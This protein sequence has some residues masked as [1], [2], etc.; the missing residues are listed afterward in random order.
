[1]RNHG[2]PTDEDRHIGDLGNIS[3]RGGKGMS[4]G[5]L[6]D[7]LVKLEGEHREWTAM[8][9]SWFQKNVFRSIL[10]Y[11]SGEKWIFVVKFTFFWNHD[12]AIAVHSL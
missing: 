6:D 9:G 1:M 2:G 7:H 3:V 8:A 10:T 11:F 12:P 4:T 5:R